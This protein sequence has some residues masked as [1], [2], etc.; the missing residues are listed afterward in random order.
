[1]GF[2]L[3][4]SGLREKELVS[5]QYVFSFVDLLNVRRKCQDKEKY[6]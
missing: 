2:W 5:K 3:L 1:M 6:I 4:F